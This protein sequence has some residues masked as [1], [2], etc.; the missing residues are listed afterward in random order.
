[1][2]PCTSYIV[3]R[4]R[5]GPSASPS[6]A[7]PRSAP[8]AKTSGGRLLDKSTGGPPAVASLPQ[9]VQKPV[10]GLKD[11][12]TTDWIA[13][14]DGYAKFYL[15]KRIPER[16]IVLDEAK[17]EYLRRLL[18][19]KKGAKARDINRQVLSKLRDS[20]VDVRRTAFQEPWKDSYKKFMIENKLESLTG[21]RGSE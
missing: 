4:Q 16:A 14:V 19:Q 11:G 7:I 13:L 21:T 15:A 6:Q 1:M 3:S 20:K 12:E 10:R 5:C 18:A 8:E 9:D 2:G 17:K